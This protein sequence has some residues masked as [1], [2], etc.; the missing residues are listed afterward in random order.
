MK[1]LVEFIAESNSG[2][3]FDSKI[4]M[5]KKE[6]DEF[7]KRFD[8]TGMYVFMT[9]DKDQICTIYETSDS[10]YGIGQHLGTYNYKTEELYY[11]KENG[12]GYN[13]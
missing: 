4:K 13:L 5:S 11:D 7:R 3:S 10:V 6:F 1:S 2:S 12:L 9:D 8:Y